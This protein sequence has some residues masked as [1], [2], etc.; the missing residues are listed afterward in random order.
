MSNRWMKTVLGRV[1]LTG[2]PPK[3]ILHY[4]SPDVLLNDISISLNAQKRCLG[5]MDWTVAQHSLA[6]ARLL[7]KAGHEVE[8]VLFALLHDAHEAF[9]GD[10]PYPLV[11]SMGD[12]FQDELEDLKFDIDRAIWK[13]LGVYEYAEKADWEIIDLWDKE[14][15]N[16]EFWAFVPRDS[17]MHSGLR[18][19]DKLTGGQS[20]LALEAIKGIRANSPSWLAAV[21]DVINDVRRKHRV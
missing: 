14:M 12:E 11:A 18:D 5:R 19:F 1:E 20:E 15:F 17:S 2:T 21:L 7:Y 6:L 4:P 9:T 16:A 13:A 8:T 3:P 10:I